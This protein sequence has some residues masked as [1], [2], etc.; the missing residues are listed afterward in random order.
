MIAFVLLFLSDICIRTVPGTGE[1]CWLA[2]G[3]IGRV[4]HVFAVVVWLR[5]R[6]KTAFCLSP[7]LRGS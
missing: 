1:V 5:Q 6:N 2:E 7:G 3:G 4:M